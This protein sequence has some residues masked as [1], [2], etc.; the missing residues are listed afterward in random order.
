MSVR[1]STAYR[2]T[3][4]VL[5]LVCL[6]GAGLMVYFTYFAKKSP[7]KLLAEARKEAAD[8]AAAEKAGK[9]ADAVLAYEKA[10]TH[11]EN[12]IAATLKSGLPPEEGRQFLG[13]LGLIRARATR[14]REFAKAAADGKPLDERLDS[15]TNE[16][17]RS[18]ASIQDRQKL[19]QCLADLRFAVEVNPADADLAKEA[20]RLELSLSPIEWREVAKAC[21]VIRKATPNDARANY[22]L[23]RAEFDGDRS[24]DG[25]KRA[26]EFL[27]TAENNKSPYWRTIWL[28]LQIMQ[29]RVAEASKGKGK[30]REKSVAEL[31]GLLFREASGADRGGPL[32]RA[33]AGDALAPLSSF[34]LDGLFGV[35]KF[36]VAFLLADKTKPPT[37]ADL[38][39]V[40]DSAVGLARRMAE[41]AA[42]KQPDSPPAEDVARAGAVVAETVQLVAPALSKASKSDWEAVAKVARD[43][44]D[45][46]PMAVG[47]TAAVGVALLTANEAAAARQ[48]GDAALAKELQD[49]AVATLETGLKTAIEKKSADGQMEYRVALLQVK[50]AA[51]E[52]ADA[53][54]PHIDALRALGTP[55]AKGVA[56]FH[57]AELAV[58][59]G[60]LDL[61]VKKYEA[62]LREK[63]VADFALRARAELATLSLAVG[64]P[65]AAVAHLQLLA[66]A[67]AKID[68][69]PPWDRFALQSKYASPDEVTGLQ[70][71]AHLSAGEQ[72]MLAEQKRNGQ[73]SFQL[74]DDIL[75]P[76]AALM[77]GLR[78]PADKDKPSPDRAAK[79]ALSRFLR[80]TGLSKEADELLTALTVDYPRSV[81]VLR[82]RANAELQRAA[83]AK[84]P[85]KETQER[86]DKMIQAFTDEHKT[87][88]AGK[89]FW[90]EWLIRTNRGEE[91]LAYLKNPVHFP[92]QQDRDLDQ[93]RAGALF[94]AG[95][96][97]EAV[98]A[99]AALPTNPNVD[100]ILL[101]T[102]GSRDDR[103]AKL[104]SALARYENNA[105]FRL[106]KAI[107]QL[108]EK[109]YEEAAEGLLGV[110]EFTAYRATARDLLE[111]TLIAYASAELEKARPFVAKLATVAPDEPAVYVGLA[112]TAWCNEDVGDPSDAWPAKKT[113]Y[114]AL[115]RWEQLAKQPSGT[116]GPTALEIGLTRVNFHQLAGDTATARQDAA[117]L[118]AQHAD[119]L[120][121]LYVLIDLNLADPDPQ[122]AKARKYLDDAKKLAPPDSVELFLREAAVR[123]ATG[124][125][126]GA[127]SELERLVAQFPDAAAGYAARIRVAD[128]Q[129]K[130]ADATAWAVKWVGKQPDND[131]AA[132]ELIRRYAASGA[133]AAAIQEAD[134][135]VKKVVERV[136]AAAAKLPADPMNSVEKQVAAARANANTLLA[137]AFFA[138]KALDEADARIKAALADAPTNAVTRRTEGDIAIA[139]QDWERAVK[140]YQALF[141]EDNSNFIAANNLAWVLVAK[142]N[143]SA[144]A[145]KL[146]EK[147]RTRKGADK[148]IAPE[149]LRVEFLDTIGLVYAAQVKA[150]KPEEARKMA[151]EMRKVF[152]PATRR[153][154]TDPRMQFWL[155]EGYTGLGETA[156]AL[157][158]YE[159]AAKLCEVPVRG[160]S[161]DER[162]AVR[163][164]ADAK[165]KKLN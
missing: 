65:G 112:L 116:P 152:E 96:R 41:E 126:A 160:M 161:D 15:S 128:A 35:H 110:I 125:V 87:V 144:E 124:D 53:L 26:E 31:R 132:L 143:R 76:V 114:A 68:D 9:P 107:T 103:D 50:G 106:Y 20:L 119:D 1:K 66:D 54:T 120:K 77:K 45:A 153:Y 139:K 73:V 63:A 163:E 25:L 138:A 11:A 10:S 38:R 83:A 82:E 32:A 75:K 98:K 13:E 147:A 74:R 8:G 89:L 105:Q 92:D 90:V 111:R 49:K 134:G 34:D 150:E 100:L 158:R 149:R 154:P 40:A 93:L 155:A 52:K 109:K 22:C 72:R 118:L 162:K 57:E 62:V 79:I 67:F 2:I 151:E 55:R 91:A 69:L 23:A 29:W 164:Q 133:K 61:A 12:G 43:F 47:E 59:R 28:K 94:Q 7:D 148:P 121:L 136:K 78:V 97:E 86:V 39:R 137:G 81:D 140:V 5:S 30:D 4:I 156:K 141:D 64:N 36:A 37:A 131:A 159:A 142:L 85:A 16:K 33:E 46:H 123:E 113:M 99:L 88:R 157:A 48:R 51:G 24:A 18:Y 84:E 146:V 6:G 17:Y 108:G 44:F 145:M 3:M 21:A 27:Q 117:R 58:R 135:L 129:G 95:R 122:P 19:G 102:A 165:R 56:D 101:Q 80:Q 60:A 42:K 127:A 14:D 104:A 70:V 130:P 71:L 115:Q